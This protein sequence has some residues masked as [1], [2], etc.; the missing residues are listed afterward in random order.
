MVFPLQPSEL[1]ERA[2]P[3]VRLVYDVRTVIRVLLTIAIVSY[4]FFG[5]VFGSRAVRFF[6][7]WTYITLLPFTGIT[8]TGLWLNLTHLYLTSIGFC[9]I[10][11]AG[12]IGVYHLLKIRRW[13]R[14]IPFLAPLIYAVLSV[15][16]A[17]QIDAQNRRAAQRPEL[18]EMRAQV[19]EILG[20]S[21][22]PPE[23]R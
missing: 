22:T 16:V 15:S 20:R 17:H 13:R 3:I 14:Y 21:E 8:G 1:L 5:I 9:I 7:A 12:S 10:L 11:S 4:S 2:N 19:E 6:I 23:P 18:V